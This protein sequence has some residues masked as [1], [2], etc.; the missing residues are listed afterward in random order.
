MHRL[1]VLLCL[2][3]IGLG[4]AACEVLDSGERYQR[5][6]SSDDLDPAYGGGNGAGKIKSGF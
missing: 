2:L 1:R 3:V 4:L 6:T 5:P